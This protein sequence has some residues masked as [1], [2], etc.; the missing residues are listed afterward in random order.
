MEASNGPE[1]T[2]IEL[3]SASGSIFR[4]VS[5]APPRDCGEEEIPIVD[6]SDIC[7]D[8]EERKALVERV[9][10]AAVSTGFF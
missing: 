1:F 9:K 8:Q 2:T 6:I 10:S 3:A 7:G 5:T 4:R